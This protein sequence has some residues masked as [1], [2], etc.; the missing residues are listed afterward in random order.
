MP[1]AGTKNDN[2]VIIFCEVSLLTIPLTI[3]RSDTLPKTCPNSALARCGYMLTHPF[4]SNKSCQASETFLVPCSLNRVLRK[5][6]GCGGG[7]GSLLS[8]STYPVQCI[9][10]HNIPVLWKVG[11]RSNKFIW[12]NLY[13]IVVNLVTNCRQSEVT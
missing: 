13:T 5:S 10:F 11:R 7:S 9:L 2:V 12:N 4:C 8:I 1:A 6:V 3:R